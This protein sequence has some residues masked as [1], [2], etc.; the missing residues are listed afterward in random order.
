MLVPKGLFLVESKTTY[1]TGI[2]AMR[3]DV[4]EVKKGIG[5]PIIGLMVVAAIAVVFLIWN[6]VGGTRTS[7]PTGMEVQKPT[8]LP[9]DPSQ[10]PAGGMM[11][12]GGVAP[13]PPGK[14]GN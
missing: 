10:L 13:L 1:G 14:G 11:P 9:P 4:S 6:M 2:K 8:G 12:R 3:Q 5:L 7:V